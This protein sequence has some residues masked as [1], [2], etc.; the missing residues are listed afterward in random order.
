MNKLAVSIAASC[1]TL[2]AH[3]SAIAGASDWHEVDGAKVRLISMPGLQPGTIKAGLQFKLENGWKTYWRSPGG[4][5]I[6]PQFQFLGSENIA[7]ANV[8]F[9]VPQFFS[10][11]NSVGYKSDVTFPIDINLVKANTPTKIN[12]SAFVGICSEIC[13]PVQFQLSTVQETLGGT[14]VDIARE[15][16]AAQNKVPGDA[17]GQQYVASAVVG[18]DEPALLS[19]AAQVPENAQTVS[20]FVEAPDNWYIEQPKL[21][22][23]S[24]TESKFQLTLNNIPKD[25]KIEGTELKVTLI[26]DGVGIEQSLAITAAKTP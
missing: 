2:F 11:D 5:G 14:K 6:P 3:Q 7:S 22:H 8:S 16:L 18:N 15:L 21:A 13:V 23:R 12:L 9:P 26:A 17:T 19:F 25:A 4:S 20:L 1:L 24:D 10:E